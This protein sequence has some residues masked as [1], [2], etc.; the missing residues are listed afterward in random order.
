ML[1]PRVVARGVVGPA[2]ESMWELKRQ[3]TE[4]FKT[5]Q[6]IVG[7]HSFATQWF[8]N[9][10]FVTSFAAFNDLISDTMTKL[11]RNLK[12]ILWQN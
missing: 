9:H 4:R 3:T 6:Y 1:L 5:D 11:K 7:L 10:T 2:R 12:G 8:G